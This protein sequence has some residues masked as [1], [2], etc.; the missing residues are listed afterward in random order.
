MYSKCKARRMGRRDLP[1]QRACP[2]GGD[3]AA[4]PP[5]RVAPHAPAAPAQSSSSGLQGA[6]QTE[7]EVS[8]GCP[9]TAVTPSLSHWLSHK[10]THTHTHQA[11]PPKASVTM[12]CFSLHTLINMQ[13]VNHTT[14]HITTWDYDGVLQ[15]IY[16]HIYLSWHIWQA[17]SRKHLPFCCLL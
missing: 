10:H 4:A 13:S 8:E 15:Q 1:R 11:K 5:A 2:P 14:P 16:L 12:S 6:T 17:K 9:V 3:T 7:S